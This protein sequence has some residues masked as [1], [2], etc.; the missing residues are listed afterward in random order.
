MDEKKRFSRI[1]SSSREEAGKTQDYM[2]DRL[3]VSK[4][5]VQ[6]WENGVTAPDMYM[7]NEWFQVLGV[8]PV[9]YYLTYQYPEWIGSVSSETDD[10]AIEQTLLALI[11]KSTPEEKRNLLFLMAGKHG[12]PWNLL[13]QLFVAHCHTSMQTRVNVAQTI[14]DSYEMEAGSRRLAYET[15]M[16]PNIQLLRDAVEVRKRAVAK[17]I[18][19]FGGSED[20]RTAG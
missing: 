10:D 16:A 1:W 14:L 5:T 7:G 9:P 19:S 20:G 2:A 4:K 18:A 17:G 12:S 11:K 15:D 8:N 3:G 13:L 6:N